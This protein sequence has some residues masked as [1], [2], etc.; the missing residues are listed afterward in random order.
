ME[1]LN[2]NSKDVELFKERAAKRVQITTMEEGD[3]L[4]FNDG[5][6]KRVA[7][8]V[9]NRVQPCDSGSFYLNDSG[10]CTMS[11]S[12][13]SSIPQNIF[14]VTEEFKDGSCWLFSENRAGAGRGVYSQI[15]FRV[16]KQ[17]KESKFSPKW[18]WPKFGGGLIL[19]P[20][21]EGYVA[22]TYSS[23]VCEFNKKFTN[24][25][26]FYNFIE[27]QGLKIAT[28]YGNGNFG[29]VPKDLPNPNE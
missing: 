6:V 24:E 9:C 25:T 14:E 17:K 18:D 20:N 27:T 11:G 15:P 19:N 22:H 2:L 1:N 13:D 4:M 26:D 21:P 29:L 28:R 7:N 23:S 5:T 8:V 3:F 16:W 12:L 10:T